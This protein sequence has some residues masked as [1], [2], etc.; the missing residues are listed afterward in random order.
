MV[1]ASAPSGKIPLQSFYLN[2]NNS[3]TLQERLT[4][5]IVELILN[6]RV[7]VGTRLPSTRALARHLGISRLTVSLVFTDLMARGYLDSRPRSGY[8][9]ADTAPYRRLTLPR[10]E[11]GA[12]HVNWQ[13]YLAHDGLE[14]RQIQKPQN[15]RSYPYPFIY[16][17]PDFQIFQSTIW[18]DCA[19]RAM[20]ARDY[21]IVADDQLAQD[22]PMLID[23]ILRNT[24][25]RRGIRARPEE[26]LL[27]I[28]AQN[29]LY[30]TA[31]MLAGPGRLG[32]IENPGYP[33]FAMALQFAGLP[34]ALA[35]VDDKGLDPTNIP[36]GATLV[37]ITPSHHIPTGATMPRQR[38]EALLQQAA[39]EDFLIV[40]D[41]Y[42]TEMSVGTSPQPALKALDEMGRVIYIGSFSK[43]LFPGLRIGFLVAPAPFIDQA[44]RVR[45]VM[46]RHPP[47]LLQRITAYFL[48]LGHYDTYLRRLRHRMNARRTELTAAL[49]KSPFQFAA[50]PRHGGSSLWMQT[51][52]GTDSALL[53]KTARERGVL[54]EPGKPFFETAQDPCPFFR[55]GY[56]SLPR[57]SIQPGVDALSDAWRVGAG[58]DGPLG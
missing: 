19:R 52:D 45:A 50:E 33:D 2:N 55:L 56:S 18:R 39:R 10:P 14:R 3:L 16:G 57:A 4:S 40:E 24:L 28:G 21:T 47:G 37:A 36:K 20:G 6:M 5:A 48:A 27:T 46:L 25:I 11:G 30:I 41:D 1:N 42:E 32:V 38:R 8:V 54:I 53:A 9:V 43:T 7:P 12:D 58:H 29:A 22:D 15:W 13:R 17:Q 34:Y 26:V 51:P 31:R 35:R 49:E 23:Y 44:R